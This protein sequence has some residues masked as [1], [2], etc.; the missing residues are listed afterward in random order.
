MM[1]SSSRRL[2]AVRIMRSPQAIY[3]GSHF[4]SSA[5][6]RS[7]LIEPSHKRPARMLPTAMRLLSAAFQHRARDV[8]WNHSAT[9]DRKEASLSPGR[10]PYLRRASCLAWA[11]S[12]PLSP[13][14]DLSANCMELFR[15]RRRIKGFRMLAALKCSRRRKCRSWSSAVRKP[16]S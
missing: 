9:A 3:S 8:H 2:F 6:A 11:K 10:V 14:L 13:S 7:N 12:T 5:I 1:L 15:I 16:S 4:G